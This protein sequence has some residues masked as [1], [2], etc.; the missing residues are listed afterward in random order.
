MAQYDAQEASIKRQQMIAKALRDSGNQGFDPAASAGRLVYARSPWE[1]INKVFQ[2]GAASYLDN[3]AEKRATDLEAT[4]TADA[5]TRLGGM[6]D[7]LTGKS[8]MQARAN[9]NAK[10]Q[11]F[12]KVSVRNPVTGVDETVDLGESP[13][14]PVYTSPEKFETNK[15]REALANFLKGH[16][17]VAASGMLQG[18]AMAEFN[19]KDP[20]KLR[21]GDVL[22]DPNKDFEQIAAGP[23]DVPKPLAE[24]RVLIN[25]RDPNSPG[26]YRSIP[27]AEFKEGMQLYERPREGSTTPP[28]PELTPEALDLAAREVLQLGGN[29]RQ[30]AGFGQAGERD[31]KNIGNRMA[32]ILKEAGMSQADLTRLRARAV[33]EAASTTQLTKQMNAVQAYEGLAKFNAQRILELIDGVDDTGIPA[34]EGWL[35]KAK[36]TGLGDVDAAEFLS[37][38]Q[39]YQTEVARIVNNPNL[40]GVLSDSAR[41][42]IQEVVSGN[43]SAPQMRRVVNRLNL[44][45]DTRGAAIAQQLEKSGRNMVVAPPVGGQPAPAAPAAPP[46]PPASD[47]PTATDAEGNVIEFRNGAWVPRVK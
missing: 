1:D 19:P 24:D 40:T 12:S 38:L 18:M 8:D 35:R 47:V 37:V 9:P 33:G 44:E 42:E 20:V 4:K 34:V 17:P 22:L 7:T 10:L 15:K 46:P 29:M 27:R 11:D 25:V 28:I 3:R 16:D 39:T 43:L 41:Q 36:R 32:Q 23:A 45:M 31:R 26:G 21:T 14:A 5:R 6:L 2:Q 30:W 13:Q